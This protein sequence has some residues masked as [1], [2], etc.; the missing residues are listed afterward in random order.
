MFR[1]LVIASLLLLGSSQS[2]AEVQNRLGFKGGFTASGFIDDVD[3][4][5]PIALFEN[6][7][8]G[9]G[10]H[11]GGFYDKKFDWFSLGFLFSYTEKQ[12]NSGWEEGEKR[13][14]VWTHQLNYTQQPLIT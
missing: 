9:M 10:F 3:V 7:S 13:D 4:G 6:R 1:F 12:V 8:P 5:L 14:G 2:F 11:I